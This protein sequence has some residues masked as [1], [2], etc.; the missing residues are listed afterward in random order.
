MDMAADH[1][2]AYPMMV[3]SC[4]L[5]KDDSSRAWDYC[6]GEKMICDEMHRLCRLLSWIYMFDI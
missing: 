1:F 2:N 5:K 4:W 6:F 3:C